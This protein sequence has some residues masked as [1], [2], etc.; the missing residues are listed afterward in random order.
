MKGAD[1]GDDPTVGA[2]GPDQTPPPTDDRPE[3]ITDFL[4]KGRLDAFADGV[5]AIAIT[6]LV[7]DLTVPKESTNLLGALRPEWPEFLGYLI[8]FAFIGGVWVSHSRLTQLMKRGDGVSFGL[9]LLLL[10]FVSLMPFSTS[11]M[12]TNLKGEGSNTAVVIYGLNLFAASLM[13]SALMRY[14]SRQ[15]DL[16]ISGLAEGELKTME[17]RRRVTLVVGGLSVI[18]AFVLPSVAVVLYIA[19]AGLLLVLPLLRAT[20]RNRR[21]R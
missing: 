15:P 12:T 9:N 19:E 3:R 18:V 11:L 21:A 6:L 16:L 5:F 2:A 17:R 20:V 10:L 4:P 7:L 14:A 8:S 1:V 13:L